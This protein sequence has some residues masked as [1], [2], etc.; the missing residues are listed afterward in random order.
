MKK[1]KLLLT[2]GAASLAIMSVSACNKNADN[3]IAQKD[4]LS[5]VYYPGGY[6]SEYLHDFCKAFLSKKLGISASE[7]TEGKHYKL[8]P[9]EDITY[10]ADY[11]LTSDARCP[12]LIISNLLSSNAV[13]QGFISNLDDVFAAEVE[14]SKGKITIED[15]ASPEA[16]EQYSFEI[17]R[18]QTAKHRFAVPWTAI[19]LSIAYN[20]T[21]L[22]QIKHSSTAHAVAEDATDANGYWNRAPE[23]IEELKAAFDDLDLY[24][25]QHNSNL[26]K[27]GWAY[28]GGTNWF[29]AFITT[30]WAQKQG[31]DEEYLYSGEGSFYDFWKYDSPEIFKQTGLQDALGAIQ[32]LL[33]ADGKYV[34]SYESVGSMTIKN[35]QQA[36]AEGKALFCLTG[37]FFEQEYAPFINE[38]KQNFK[39][40]RVP[41]IENAL[42]N[43]DGT[44]K[45]LTYLNISSCAYVPAKA[46]NK[47]L[48]K[49][50]LKFTSSEANLVEFTK[51]T[52]GIRPF[53]YDVRE[54]AKDYNFSDFKKSV[55]DL[56]YDADDYLYKFPRNIAVE[57]I[58]PIYL[59]ESVS[60]SIF[61]GADYGTII[62]SLKTMTPKQ[63]MIDGTASFA[64]IYERATKAFNEWK[65]I[66]NL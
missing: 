3:S 20:D 1:V 12:D 42:K 62:S 30:W 7:V 48:A 16:I 28:N 9:D 36:F 33:I 21:L 38:S 41:A 32:D 31:V 37:D 52:G 65:R 6:G 2:L 56:Y 60:E 51:K 18:G 53:N 29:E 19:P 63:I 49:D 40:M 61:V 8:I 64:S 44:T 27:L 26:A 34:N 39:L 46:V 50:F 35:A 15:F 58:S 17:R 57:D 23:T 4:R 59:Y 47:D 25:Q 22:H 66:Y 10:G 5:I 24:N 14:T 43:G 54:L 55:F 11:Y 13:T 45:K